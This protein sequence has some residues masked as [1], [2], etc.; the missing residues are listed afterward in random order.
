MSDIRF[1]TTDWSSVESIRYPGET[2]GAKLFIV[3]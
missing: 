1:G 2:G 3:D